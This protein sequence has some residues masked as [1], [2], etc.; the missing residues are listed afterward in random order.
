[1][2]APSL[3]FV[4]SKHRLDPADDDCRDDNQHRRHEHGHDYS[5]RGLEPVQ[6][7]TRPAELDYVGVESQ[8]VIVELPAP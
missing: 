8:R 6:R 2:L 7:S 3:W 4:F 5:R 1:M